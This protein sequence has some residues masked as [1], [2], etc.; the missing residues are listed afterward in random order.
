MKNKCNCFIGIVNSYDHDGHNYIYL[1]DYVDKL[2]ELTNISNNVNK[3][4]YNDT[5]TLKPIDFFDRRKG[6][7]RLFNYCPNCGEKINYKILKEKLR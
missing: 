1:D 7:S 2:I 6:F 3:V 5:L 4:L